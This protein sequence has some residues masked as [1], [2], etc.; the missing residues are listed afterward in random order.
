MLSR[1]SKLCR[2]A[3]C[4]H[5]YR[6]PGASV[7]LRL[8][9]SGR[10]VR[11]CECR[12]R[13]ESS[14]P[15]L[16]FVCP[17]AAVQVDGGNHLALVKLKNRPI[18]PIGAPRIHLAT[19]GSGSPSSS[20][21]AIMSRLTFANT[22]VNSSTCFMDTCS[23]SLAEDNLQKEKH[24]TDNPCRPDDSRAQRRSVQFAHDVKD[25]YVQRRLCRAFRLEGSVAGDVD[26]QCGAENS[27]LER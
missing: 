18:L 24:N 26:H 7:H 9:A 12:R 17:I 4:L 15:F 20:R 21:F 2:L 6:P 19:D 23:C 25:S 11:S 5:R 16:L 10:R 27:V 3:V 14:Q 8:A 13:V 22:R 1:T